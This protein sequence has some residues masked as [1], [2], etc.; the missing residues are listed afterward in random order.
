MSVSCG[1][2]YND[3]DKGEDLTPNTYVKFLYGHLIEE[4]LLFLTRAAGHKVTDEQKKC[5]VLFSRG[6]Q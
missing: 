2:V 1:M 4:L 3:V 5:E 6:I